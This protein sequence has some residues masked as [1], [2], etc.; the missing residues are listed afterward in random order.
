M[1]APVAGFL[2]GLFVNLHKLNKEINLNEFLL[3]F[4]IVGP[5]EEMV[6]IAK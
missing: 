2:N 5:I 6:K 3:H 1:L 4:T